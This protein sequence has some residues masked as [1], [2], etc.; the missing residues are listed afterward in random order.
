MIGRTGGT[1]QGKCRPARAVPVIMVLLMLVPPAP[2][3]G[4]G[5]ASGPV[6]V[7]FYYG[8][9]EHYWANA[10]SDGT[11]DAVAVS[12]AAAGNINRGFTYDDATGAAEIGGLRPGANDT[13]KWSLLEWDPAGERWAPRD[14]DPHGLKPRA[15]GAIAWSPNTTAN[16]TPNPLGKYPWPM[17]RCTPSRRGETLSP[18]PLTNLTYWTARLNGSVYSTPCVA[19]GRIFILAG[20]KFDNSS[21]TNSSLVCLDELGGRV[22]WR[23]E[24][25]CAGLEFSSPAYSDGKVYVGGSDGRLRAFDA[26]SGTVLWSFDTGKSTFGLTSSPAVW[27]GRVL[28]ASAD[29]FLHCLKPDGTLDWKTNVSGPA[30]VFPC[31]PSVLSDMILVGSYSGNVSCLGLLNGSI[32][33]TRRLPGNI[34]ATMPLSSEGYAFAGAVDGNR[35]LNLSSMKIYSIYLKSGDIQWNASYPISVSSPALAAGGLFLGTET[36]FVGHHPDRGTRMW[37]IP[38][39]TGFTSPAV[40]RG[41]EYFATY[42]H[43]HPE[44][45]SVIGSVRVGGLLDW[46]LAV[47]ESCLASPVVADGRLFAVSENGTVLCIGRPPEPRVT[48]VLSAPASV[49]SGKTVTVKAA[50]NNA[51]EAPALFTVALTVDGKRTDIRKGP[52]TLQPGE[53]MNISFGWKAVKGNHTLGLSYNGTNGA[54]VPASI[55]VAKPA[56]ACSSAIWPPALAAI[57]LAAPSIVR[58]ARRRDR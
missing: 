17:F 31:S 40:A 44:D 38:F 24:L 45:G 54:F 3:E 21:S 30:E 27:R 47:N 23:S 56:E 35:S 7:M 29:G 6:S 32:L 57:A 16:P 36:E 11:A 46:T 52:F 28:V 8:P 13:W 1:R 18:A 4:G 22:V 42:D 9:E 19:G 12:K 51:G 39:A 48:A 37:G 58:W 43:T 5:A 25:G 50:L 10:T 14:G 20:G 41:Y 49:A 55:S 34:L 15:G 33:W 53:R 2:A 26:R